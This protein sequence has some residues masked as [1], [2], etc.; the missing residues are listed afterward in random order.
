MAGCVMAVWVVAIEYAGADL[1]PS[2]PAAR[3]PVLE[4][5]YDLDTGRFAHDHHDST[6]GRGS[7]FAYGEGSE[8]RVGFEHPARGWPA[9]TCFTRCVACGL[10][11]TAFVTGLVADIVGQVATELT[12]WAIRFTD[13]V[14]DD[15]WLW[16]T[17]PDPLDG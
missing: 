7:N 11:V 1:Q 16:E 6:G 10:A 15:L 17:P 3:R 2:H 4:H 5:A 13:L 12:R 9:P 8:L 14:E